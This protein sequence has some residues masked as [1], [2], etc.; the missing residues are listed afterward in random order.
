[1]SKNENNVIFDKV[2]IIGI[3]LIGS[4][5]AKAIKKRKISNNISGYAKTNKTRQKVRELGYIDYVEDDLVSA[6]TDADLIILCVPVGSNRQ[7]LKEISSSLK[8]GSILTDVGSVKSEVI[9]Q[10]SDIIPQ[11][12]SFIPGH[13]IAGTEFSGPESGFAELIED[14]WCILTP[15]GDFKRKDLNKVISFWEGIGMLVDIMEPEQHDLVL[16]ITSHIPH[17]IAYNIVGTA[18]DLEKVTK[19]EVTKY[20]AGGFR[21]FTR[22]ASSDPIMWRDI[23]L[24]NK[25]A[26]LEMLGRFT[27]DLADLQKAI[28]WQDGK[29]LEELFTKTRKIR[30]GIIKE[31]KSRY[32][33]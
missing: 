1:M 8:K 12:V 16:A 14:K 3:G 29:R 4:S 26:V 19:K 17:L 28:R 6:V 11:G 32:S 23:F 15:Y 20:A 10:V 13:P 2:A 9:N 22:I 27:E 7:I 33:K 30:E 24:N 18:T 21:D 25:E 5:I 31:E